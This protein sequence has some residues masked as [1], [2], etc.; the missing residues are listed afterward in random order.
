MVISAFHE[1][2]LFF[3]KYIF[4][5]D[6]VFL[7]ITPLLNRFDVEWLLCWVRAL[8]AT[9]ISL[10]ETVYWY[11]VVGFMRMLHVSAQRSSDDL[12]SENVRRT[13]C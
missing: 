4:F 6:H 7:D 11:H 8:S 12:K 3:L 1:F 10:V 9:C 2:G 5:L 13:L